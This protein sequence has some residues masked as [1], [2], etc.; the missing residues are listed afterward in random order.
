MLM[1][2]DGEHSRIGL[3]FLL[4]LRLNL[5]LLF[6]CPFPFHVVCVL[7]LSLL[8]WPQLIMSL[9]ESYLLF[10]CHIMPYISYLLALSI[11]VQIVENATQS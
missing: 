3:F 9:D 10:R 5:A 11:F 7:V 8:V 4:Y 2:L 6:W 1:A